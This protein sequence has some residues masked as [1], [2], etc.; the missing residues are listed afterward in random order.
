MQMPSAERAIPI[1][2]RPPFVDEVDVDLR[3]CACRECDARQTKPGGAAAI[4][5]PAKGTKTG[6][7]LTQ[8]RLMCVQDQ[9]QV[10]TVSD[11]AVTLRQR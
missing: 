2:V 11:D 3:F 8:Q 6:T 10:Q 9:G 4:L 1:L 7:P 5:L